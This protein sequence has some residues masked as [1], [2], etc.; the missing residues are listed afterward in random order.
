M[1]D[2]KG[3]SEAFIDRLEVRAYSRA[4]E[5]P[6]R[7]TAAILNIFPETVRDKVAISKAKTDGHLGIPIMIHVGIL[8]DHKLTSFAIQEIFSNFAANELQSILNTLEL[9]IDEE[10]T[11]FLRIDKQTAYLEDIELAIGSDVISLQ[12][13][14]MKWPRCSFTDA[15]QLIRQLISLTGVLER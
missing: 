4:T 15:E 11:L 7:V 10:C 3:T 2:S 6:E 9:R 8:D 5:V 14:I 1:S 12:V 13:H